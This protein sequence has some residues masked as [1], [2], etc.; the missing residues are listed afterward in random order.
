M[1]D[2]LDG[3][4][5]LAALRGEGITAQ[6]L[7]DAIRLL[8]PLAELDP[9]IVA[10]LPDA[11]IN[12]RLDKLEQNPSAQALKLLRA[13]LRELDMPRPMLNG[14]SPPDER[15]VVQVCRLRPMVGIAHAGV[16]LTD[17]TGDVALNRAIFGTRLEHTEARVERNATITGTTGRGYSRQS[18][19]GLDQY[20]RP[21]KGH[22]ASAKRLR[23]DI[24]AVAERMPGKTLFAADQRVE[25]AIAPLL[26]EGGPTGHFGNGRGKN[27]WRDCESVVVA[28][29]PPISMQDL[30]D[31]ARCYLAGDPEPFHS[32]DVPMPDDWPVKGWPYVCTRMR[33]MVDGTLAPVEVAVHPD[34]RLQ[35]VWE[36]IREAEIVQW[37]DRTPADAAPPQFRPAQQSGPR[38]HLQ[39]HPDAC[40]AGG[41]RQP[42]RAGDGRDRDPAARGARSARPPPRPLPE[43][44]SCGTGAR[45]YPPI[46]N[47]STVYNEGVF[48]RR[49][50]DAGAARK[51]E[52]RA[53][54]QPKAS[55]SHSR[56]ECRNY[57]RPRPLT[58]LVRAT[59]AGTA[60]P[61]R[62]AKPGT[63][64][65]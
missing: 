45:K 14:I 37:A 35:R 9:S 6:H 19:T 10:G 41:R 61:G 12:K 24:A 48:N 60:E 7:R 55:R 15:G 18:L 63:A 3:P 22:Q 52:P 33:R 2:A 54:R 46:A 23:H 51:T 25:A 34:P 62:P 50:P 28:G 20:D 27:E 43:P 39:S 57:G 49:L 36:Q 40:R 32:A 56:P 44:E 21:I 4:D 11:E 58:G 53:D 64:H 17:G 29:P 59:P 31:L 1:R 16:L 5:Q 65:A 26:S 38:R 13:V 8:V 42:V 30:E 47:R